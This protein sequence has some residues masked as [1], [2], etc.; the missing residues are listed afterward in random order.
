M[1]FLTSNR[2]MLSEKFVNWESVLA[3]FWEHVIFNFIRVEI[4]TISEVF[5]AK[6]Y[7]KMSDLFGWFFLDLRFSA[8]NSGIKET[9]MMSTG[10][11]GL[12]LNARKNI[13]KKRYEILNRLYFGPSFNFWGTALGRFSQCFFFNF[14]FLVNHGNR[15]FHTAPPPPPPQKSFLWFWLNIIF[16]FKSSDFLQLHTA[17]FD[18]NVVLPFLVFN[19]FELT[20]SAVFSHFKNYVN[21]FSND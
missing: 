19:T 13:F 20:F 10:T 11:C 5:W 9:L 3:V 1:L 12:R 7:F 16:A 2:N 6:R 15:Y 18:N 8:T 4:R 21:I 17:H 14:S